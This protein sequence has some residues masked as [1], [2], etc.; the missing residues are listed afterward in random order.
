MSVQS[1]PSAPTAYPARLEVD[2]AD[3]FDRVKT[4]FGVFLVI[5]VAIVY[6]LLTAG[7]TRTVYDESG[8]MVS[9]TSSGIVS[10]LFLA[11]LLMIGQP[12]SSGVPAP[13]TSR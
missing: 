11:T 10:G 5:P 13:S 9:T 1:T 4:L 8:R 6:G 12:H 3:R 2:Y 7:V